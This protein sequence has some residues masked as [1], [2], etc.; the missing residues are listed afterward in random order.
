[1]GFKHLVES[2]VNVLEAHLSNMENM[3]NSGRYLAGMTSRLSHY[4]SAA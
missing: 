1:M 4:K 3:D 2:E